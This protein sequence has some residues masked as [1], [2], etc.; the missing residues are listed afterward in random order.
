M[1]FDWI[2]SPEAW[3][4]LASLTAIEIVLG[5]DNVVFISVL[6]SKL[7]PVERERARKIG[8]GLAL[9]FRIIL[10]FFLSWIIGLTTPVIE[11]AQFSFSWRDLVLIGG[12]LFLLT[13]ATREVHAEIEGGHQSAASA[14]EGAFAWVVAQV[15]VIDLV[16]SVDSIVTAIGMAQDIQVM[17]IAV[18]IAVAVMYIS[19]GPVSTFIAKHPTTKMLALAFL[20]LIG[21]A[22]IADGF[23]FHIPRAYIYFAMAF[24]AVVEVINVIASGNRKVKKRLPKRPAKK[25]R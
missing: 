16:F 10:L 21:V 25:R 1:L 7:K 19:S 15:I 23:A 6:V 18:I 13:K 24:A 9:I 17:I 8:L 5:I 3:I 4:A 14:A 11:F 22:L 20:M 12:G 2:Y